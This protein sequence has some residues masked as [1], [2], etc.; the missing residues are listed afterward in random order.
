MML[1]VILLVLLLL[2]ETTAANLPAKWQ[3]LSGG[4]PL[5]IAQGGFSGVFPES[6]QYAYQFAQ[7]NSVK[8]VVLY[9]DLQMTKD[10]AGICHTDYRLDNSTTI[11]SVFPK[12][13]KTYPI[14]GKQV[15]GWFA[16]DFT[17]D[18][19]YN[20]VS[21]IQSIYSRPSIFDGSL[22]ISMVEDVTELHPS[23]FWINLQFNTF[24]KA[25]N[26]DAVDYITSV[27]GQVVIDYISSPEI[28]FLRSLMGKLGRSKTKLIF[29]FLSV[30]DVE[31]STKKT[32]QAFLTDLA[33]IKSFAS[34]IL[35]PKSY[36]WPVNHDQYLEPHTSLVADAHAVGLEVYADYFANDMPASYNYSFDPTAEYLQFIDNSDFSVD[37]VLTDFPSTASEAI[38]CLAHNDKNV[39]PNKGRPLIITHNGASGVYAGSTDLAYQQAVADGA[40]IIDCSVQMSKDGVAFCLESPDL[41]G[42]STAVQTF[43]S[44][45]TTVPE[46][47]SNNGIFSFDLSW[48][49]ILSLKPA[50]TS[51]LS[52]AGLSR[53]PAAKNAGKFMTLGDFLNFAKTSTVSGVLINIE[54]AAY[55]A[56]KKGLGIVDAVSTALSNAS[57]D[58]QPNKQIFIQSDDI[59]VLA[60][61]KKNP[62]YTRVLSIKETISDAPKPTVDEIKQFADAVDLPRT[63]IVADSGS[64]I[65]GFTDVVKKMHAANISVHASVFR[66]EYLAI[67]FDYFS[68]PMVEL[69]TFV[70][71]VEVD[72]V[73]TE[74]PATAAAY[75][76]S[77]CSDLN[78]KLDY[79]ILPIEPG[80]LLALAPPEALPPAEAPAPALQVADIQDPPLPPV[81]GRSQT[82]S[83]VA[84]PTTSPSG[85]PTNA[86]SLSVCLL[87][88]VLS[89][90]C[91]MYQ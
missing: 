48:S 80:S 89:C 27:S 43:M 88:A 51:P 8:N 57:Y 37:G 76:R 17:S 10:G 13:Q 56:S 36:I 29:R 55:L 64:F 4:A 26:L 75:L 54:N 91:V 15:R 81:I 53:N 19:L 5:V 82:S 3:T 40:D 71:G 30:D 86:A 16:V 58:Q 9:C 83:V 66:N 50:L 84:P 78:A 22:P 14:N 35:V 70:A 67:A 90:L 11:S 60:V 34:G 61:F 44:L 52:Q 62:S 7:A 2:H 65:S 28:D 68:D 49:D 12:G 32:Y 45:A 39:V 24:F 77:P 1:R 85:Q 23:Q 42:H 46:I 47:Q 74:F 21:L 69:A 18:Q 6:S 20:N 33:T 63:S 87:A 59:Q 38:A 31:P 73:V 41:M 25:H 79:S 72:A